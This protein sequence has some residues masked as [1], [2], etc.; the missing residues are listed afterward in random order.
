MMGMPCWPRAGPT[1][2]AGVAAPAGRL[3]L[4]IIFTFF[5]IVELYLFDL[6]E[7]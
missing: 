1:G 3:S 5:A 7:V 4:R 2:G 6:E